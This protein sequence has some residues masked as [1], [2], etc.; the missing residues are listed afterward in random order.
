MHFR[1]NL[2]YLSV[3]KYSS[4][5][6]ERFLNTGAILGASGFSKGLGDMIYVPGAYL[7][8]CFV[9]T[10]GKK[11]AFIEAVTLGANGAFYA[12]P[13]P[14]MADQKAYPYQASLFAGLAI[15][16]RWK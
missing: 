3:Q 8:T 9:I 15:G 4:A 16:K 13:L 12:R 10:P 14:I 6:S 11:K 2:P 5:N 1:Y 7:E